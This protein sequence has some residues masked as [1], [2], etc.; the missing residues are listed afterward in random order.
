MSAC[1]QAP[2]TPRAL[3]TRRSLRRPRRATAPRTATLCRHRRRAVAARRGPRPERRG[4][5]RALRR[6]RPG[7][8]MWRE[9]G[10]PPRGVARLVGES[11]A[12]RELRD[13]IPRIAG[14]PFPVVIEGG[15][16]R[17]EG[18]DRAGD[19]RGGPAGAGRIRPGQLRPARR[20]AVRLGAVRPR[21]GR[22]LGHPGSARSTARVVGD[23]FDRHGNMAL[24][25]GE[26]GITSQGRSKLMAQLKIDRTD[27]SRAAN[28]PVPTV[29]GTSGCELRGGGSRA[30][31]CGHPLPPNRIQTLYY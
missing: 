14:S 29:S 2:V 26:P 11:G 31:R 13:R 10:V 27:P 18:A 20:R 28:A 15:G 9:A 12:M 16:H 7:R 25:A 30:T 21:P 22:V 23:A 5:G 1:A 19:P 17:E 8:M 24:A 4:A 6:P 3:P